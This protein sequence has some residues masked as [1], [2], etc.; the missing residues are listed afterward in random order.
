M[1]QGERAGA[2]KGIRTPVASL[3]GLSPGPLDD[4]GRLFTR[5]R[6]SITTVGVPTKSSNPFAR[7][8]VNFSPVEDSSKLP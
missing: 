1:R 6:F 5:Q 3:K 4:G 8:K 7:G 2:P